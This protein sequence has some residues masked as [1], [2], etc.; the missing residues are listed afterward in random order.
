[1]CVANIFEPTIDI[2]IR[3][4]MGPRPLNSYCPNLAVPEK[5]KRVINFD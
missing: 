3:V 2:Y 4:I 1:M 5:K